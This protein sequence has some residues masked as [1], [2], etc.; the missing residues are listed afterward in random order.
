MNLE[1]RKKGQ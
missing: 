1:C